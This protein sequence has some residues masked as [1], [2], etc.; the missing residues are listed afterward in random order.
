M[1]GFESK[2][3]TV[4]KE[5]NFPNT[6]KP[7]IS[8]SAGQDSVALLRGVLS[9]QSALKL[10]E[11]SVVYIHHGS[12]EQTDQQKYRQ[13]AEEFVK[14]LCEKFD[15]KFIEVQKPTKVLSSEEQFRDFRKS[16]Y[17]KILQQDNNFSFWLAQHQ[18]DQLETRLIR[19]IRG[20]GPEGFK[21][22]KVYSPPYVRPLLGFT[23]KEIHN[24][25][26]DIG[27]NWLEDPS[28]NSSEYFRNWIRNNW[29][30]Q[31]EDYRPG[32]TQR[33]AES[34]EQLS[35][36]LNSVQQDIFTEQGLDR[37][38]FRALQRSEQKQA[39]A[40]FCQSKGVKNYTQGQ[41]NELLKHLDRDEKMFTLDI[42]KS[43]WFVDAKHITV[44]F[45][46]QD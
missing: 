16:C 12:S 5:Q 3:L 34:L 35:D 43:R 24:Y 11:L 27:Q 21:A 2:L 38:K 39:L 9:I 41:F 25:L 15:L 7:V 26:L 8:V 33:L 45:K 22:M 32:S 18:Q 23:Q 36:N 13:Q 19:L 28:N 17:K 29:L 14:V 42:M 30:K 1:H 46:K 20:T 31:L 10:N 4:L 6:M 40:Q 37:L 44:L